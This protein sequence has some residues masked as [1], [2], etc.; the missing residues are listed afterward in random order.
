[1]LIR[2]AFCN[3]HY[4]LIHFRIPVTIGLHKVHTV[5][6]VIEGNPMK[7]EKWQLDTTEEVAQRLKVSPET[8]RDWRKRGIGPRAV[9]V[10]RLVR[11]SRAD[12]TDWLQQTNG[13]PGGR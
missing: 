5:C 8:L 6:T 10:G 4:L 7:V 11:Y 13:I 1:L 9:K 2:L 12:V 3:Q